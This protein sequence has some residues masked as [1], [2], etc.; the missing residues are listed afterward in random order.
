MRIKTDNRTSMGLHTLQPLQYG[1]CS[2]KPPVMLAAL[3]WVH[4]VCQCPSGNICQC[5]KLDTVPQ[6]CS[7]QGWAEGNY[8]CL[9]LSAAALL[10]TQHSMYLAS[11]LQGQ[12]FVSCSTCVHYN[13]PLPL[14]SSRSFAAE[15]LTSQSNTYPVVFCRGFAS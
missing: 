4:P 8:H 13:L 10:Q 5:P 7:H 2:I 9:S 3:H 12:A 15:L 11:F 1:T 14:T 6:L